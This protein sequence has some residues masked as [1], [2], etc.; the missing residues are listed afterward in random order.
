MDKTKSSVVKGIPGS[1]GIA[2]GKVF[3]IEEDFPVVLKK[4]PKSMIKKEISRLHNALSQVREEMYLEKHKILKVLGKEHAPLADVYL[5]ILDDPI[6]KKDVANRI[7]EEGINA[8]HA[9]S[10][11][12]EKV[13]QSFE[14]IEDEY[15]NE[16]KNDIQE[17]GKRIL[18]HL[19]GSQRKYINEANAD[20]TIVAHNLTPADT[21]ALY[22]HKVSA[23]AIDIGS[24]TA[25]ASLLAQGLEI[26]AVVGLKNITA[27]ANNGDD[28]IVDGNQG[29]VI[30]NPDDET[31]ENYRKEH[32]IEQQ[33]LYELKKL[34]NVAAET[35]DGHRVTLTGNIDSIKEVKSI[36]DSGAE[37]VGL[38]RTEFLY[39]N[40]DKLPSEEEQYEIYSSIAQKVLPYS[41]T[42][43]TIDL[44]GDKLAKFGFDDI[45]A[46]DNPFLG[47]RSLRLC[48]KYP[49]VF[50]V[51]LKA[52]LRASAKGKIKVMFPM[53]TGLAEFRQAKK[54]FEE[55]KEVLRKNIQDFDE[56]IK[57][58]AMIET[59]SA[60]LTA[61]A[62]A[63]EA[64]FLSIG[65]NDLIQ[66]TLAVDRV[67]ENVA[68]MYEP[69]HL[70]ILRL[71][72]HIIEATHSAAK[73]V[74]MCGEMAGDPAFTTI[75]MGLG[76]DE[77]SVP[78][79]AV[80]KIK[81]IIRSSSIADSKKLVQKIFGTDDYNTV[82]NLLRKPHQKG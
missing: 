70:S 64:D 21:V 61:D 47:L 75:L 62:I 6:L 65:T 29:L 25:H 63:R 20:S 38:F 8:E 16:R 24:K 82:V 15:F 78:P 79:I 1:P 60:A 52:I 81:K 72:R 31:L 13:V 67:N 18:R 30:V 35:I 45:V 57:L 77:F 14:K 22:E 50:V 80:P 19:M 68:F 44:G 43:R 76:L 28:V 34:R 48:L 58:G 23:F 73:L 32:E 42:I 4:I 40:R 49:E 56:N 10:A 39:M 26:P 11:T 12:I 41:L 51:Q 33:E 71:L 53:V 74:G 69:L 59:P 3:L 27:I 55:T 5:R 17:V 2:I 9:L 36:L 66:Y 46:E 37:G 54:I 7:S